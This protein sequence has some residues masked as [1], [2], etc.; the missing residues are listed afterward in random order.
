M[1]GVRR[2]RASCA[3]WSFGRAGGV[4]PSSKILTMDHSSGY[5]QALRCVTSQH[6]TV[7]E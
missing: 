5:R 2:S 6:A 4:E 3:R 7:A 1:A